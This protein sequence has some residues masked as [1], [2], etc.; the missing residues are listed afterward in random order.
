M[1]QLTPE[2]YNLDMVAVLGGL[3]VDPATVIADSAKVQ[4]LQ[5][6]AIISYEVMRAVPARVL[7]IALLRG[8]PMERVEESSTPPP[9]PAPQESTEPEPVEEAG[10]V[11]ELT[12]ESEE[13]RSAA[14]DIHDAHLKGE[15]LNIT[16]PMCGLTPQEYEERSA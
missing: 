13:M 2:D 8:T 16:C 6:K 4:F 11:T 10:S 15:G 3:G 9:D 12:F 14:F 1:T 5:G 7:A